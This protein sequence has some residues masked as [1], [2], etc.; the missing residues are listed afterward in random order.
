MLAYWGGQQ[1]KPRLPGRHDYYLPLM[2]LYELPIVIAAIGGIVHAARR[3]TRFTDLL[4]WWAFT[5]FVVYA[6]ANEKVPWLLTHIMLPLILLAGV[7]LGQLTLKSNPGRSAFAAACVLG[8]IFLLRGVSATNF[9]R[10]ADHHEPLFYAQTTEAYHDAI[11]DGLNR[12]EGSAGIVWVHPDKQWPAAWYFRNGAP[13]LG[14]STG[15]WGPDPPAEP[16]RMAVH[17]RDI[18]WQTKIAEKLTTVENLQKLKDRLRS[19]KH[20]EVE[21]YIWTRPSW[22]ALRPDRFWR[23]WWSRQVDVKNP[24]APPPGQPQENGILTGGETS[25]AYAVVSTPQ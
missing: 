12:T 5:S 19:W 22:P 20:H 3:R 9:E 1:K 18:D 16:M 2:L 4:L 25:I 8:A 23:F 21:Y 17:L 13:Y 6:I 10:P 15:A 14:K 7:W 11:F 24:P